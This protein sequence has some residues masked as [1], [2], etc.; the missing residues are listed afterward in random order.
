MTTNVYK[1][2]TLSD[3]YYDYTIRMFSH[4]YYEKTKGE[5]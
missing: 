5:L 2:V 3:Q 4:Y 1:I